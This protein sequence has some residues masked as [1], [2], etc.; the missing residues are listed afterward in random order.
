MTPVGMLGLLQLQGY[1]MHQVNSVFYAIN[2]LKQARQ[3]QGAVLLRICWCAG[4]FG[5]CCLPSFILS[6]Y[7]SLLR[8]YY[9][10]IYGLRRSMP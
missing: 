10:C 4:L 1:G 7:F 2:E 6:G 3:G 9:T 5:T 8:A